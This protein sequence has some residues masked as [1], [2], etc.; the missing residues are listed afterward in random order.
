MAIW[1]VIGRGARSGPFLV[2]AFA[3]G[4]AAAPLARAA[5]QSATERAL[6]ELVSEAERLG[7]TTGVMV[8]DVGGDRP[9]F[10]HRALEAFA[11]ASNM[12]LLSAVAAVSGLGSDYR[13]ETRF[14]LRSGVLVVRAGGDPTWRE[15]TAQDPDTILDRALAPLREA[16]IT[17]VRGVELD[18]GVFTGD[19]RPRGWPKDQLDRSYC[20]PTG[21]LVLEEG[22]F[23]VRIRAGRGAAARAT[24]LGPA[25][26]IPFS[27]RIRMTDDRRKGS[28]YGVWD[29]GER[30]RLIG[31]FYSRARPV[32]VVGAVRDPA[33]WFRAA[34]L[35]ALDRAGIRLDTAA[36]E[37]DLPAF[38]HSSP[39][40]PAVRRALVHSSN[41]ASEQTI[42]VLG[43]ELLG[44]GSLAGGIAAMRAQ[45]QRLVG[46]LPA[47]TRLVDASGLSKGNRVTPVLLADVLLAALSQEPDL[48]ATLP[49]PGGPGTL[50]SRF[51][52]SEV[53][54]RVRAK[55][56][57]IAGA[58]AL[59]GVLETRDGQRRVFAILM[60]Y[61]PGR[62]GLNAQLKKLQERMVEAMD[63][64]AG[65]DPISAAPPARSTSADGTVS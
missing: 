54:S 58:S 26:G 6:A 65:G 41:F 55:T 12:K 29:D 46:N 17:R 48:I 19:L 21:G 38:V 37:I 35:E 8:L 45:L 43:R 2:L 15:G 16:G 56:G 53:A 33:T 49:S 22:C 36:P 40:L 18:Q 39:L 9:V 1:E 61:D 32:R 28:V 23:T 59:S 34:L 7:T 64:T 60:N 31:N 44:D 13:F 47:S 5:P 62:G 50:S 10:A 57:W 11:P 4:A 14:E 42:R 63:R 52:G 20:A 51:V 3:V 30:L 24:L 27:G 25:T